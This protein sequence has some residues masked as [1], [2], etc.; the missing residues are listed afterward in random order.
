MNKRS[1]WQKTKL[2]GHGLLW[3][4]HDELDKRRRGKPK[5]VSWDRMIAK[6]K[7]NFLPKDFDVQMHK[8]MQG[9]R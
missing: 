5:I 4:D 1:D 7:G 6:M 9:L 2:K 3:W 8:K